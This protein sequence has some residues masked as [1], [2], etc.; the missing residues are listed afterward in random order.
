MKLNG[1]R[2]IFHYEYYWAYK[3][4]G[5]ITF[6]EIVDWLIKTSDGAR[7]FYDE[8]EVIAKQYERDKDNAFKA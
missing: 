4:E 3:M 8:N 6:K 7:T 5:K 1:W 2:I